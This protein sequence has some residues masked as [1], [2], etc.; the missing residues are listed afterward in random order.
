MRVLI[1]FIGL[2]WT[3]PLLTSA[4]TQSAKLKITPLTDQFWVYTTY[5]SYQGEQTPAHGMYVVTDDG[6]VM[7]DSPWDSTQCQPLLDSIWNRHQKRVVWCVAT[8]WH[9]DKTNGLGYFNRQGIRTYTTVRTDRFSREQ[10]KNRSSH[11]ILRDTVFQVGSLRFETY[12][13][14]PG[15]TDDNIVVW[16]NQQRVLYGGCLIKG[17]GDESLGYLGDANKTEYVRSLQ[18]VKKKFKQPK[19]IVIAHS[20][21][22][23]TNSLNHSIQLARELRRSP[24]R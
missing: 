6:V 9:G 5:D 22:K 7:M 12:Y 17:A 11:F 24:L 1:Y 14:G 10:G 19:F 15:H 23:D 20:D 13:P 2:C 18:R 4:Q 21:W 16:F 3:S 8:H